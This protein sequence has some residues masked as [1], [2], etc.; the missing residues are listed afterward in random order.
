MTVALAQRQT[1]EHLVREFKAA[2]TK[3]RQGF[4]LCLEA[5][6]ALNAAFT[7]GHHNSFHV[8]ERRHAWISWNQADE[9]IERLTRQAWVC[10]VERLELRRMMSMARWR[11]LQKMLNE[12]EL[13]PIEVATVINF[14]AGYAVS[15][16]TMVA[17]AVAEAF[18]FLRPHAR[19]NTFKTNSLYEVGERVILDGYTSWCK[20][21]ERYDVNHH[22]EQQLTA[23]ERVFHALDGRGV[24]SKSH[25][26]DLSNAIKSKT[27]DGTGE[28]EY[29]AFKCYKKGTLHLR[30]KRLDLLKRLNEV[31]GGATLKPEAA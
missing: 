27:C 22:Y 14:A 29:F 28:T 1:V 17:E 5:E 10:I 30:F 7:L 15:V 21:L 25:Y 6:H 8:G 26:S 23:I 9:A 20:Y 24:V 11:E 12:G 2:E 16:D 19:Y 3:V 31:A 4:A 18:N 13:P